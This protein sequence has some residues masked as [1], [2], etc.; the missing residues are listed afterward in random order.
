MQRFKA[1]I[2]YLFAALI[3]F[4]PIILWPYTS[5]VFEFNKIVLV[6]L[7]TTLIVGIWIARSILERKIIFR[8]TILDIPL[9][10][11]I[12]SQF[13]S[14]IIS[15][16]PL[17]SWLGYYSRFNGGL[18][19]VICYSLLYWAFVANFWKEDA[20]K[21]IK[22]LLSSAVLVSLYGILEHF[23]ID[24]DI[25]VQDVQSRVFSTL[26]QPNWLG[27]WITA[28]IPTTWIFVI[29]SKR[30]TL[31]F[32][33]YSTLSILF[34]WVLIFTKS[35]SGILGFVVA[36]AIFWTGYFWLNLKEY[37]KHL[38]PFMA[39]CLSFLAICLISGTQFTPSL[40][41][42]FKNTSHQKEVVAQGPALETGGTESGTIR[43]IVW[44]GAMQVWLHYPV[45]GA[46]V[47]T[48]AFSYY[49][50][51]PQEHNLVSEW[52]FIYN[53]AHNDFLNVAANS[54]TVGLL[55]YL[56]LIG[57]AFYLFAKKFVGYESRVWNL[58]L[59][60]GFVSLSATN[61]FGFS[62]V[63]TQIEFFLF[64]AFAV[65]LAINQPANT[66]N[67]PEKIDPSQKVLL[68]IIAGSVLWILIGT[69][70]YW[71]ADT[72]FANGKAYNS[73]GDSN[74][75]IDYLTKAT[76]LEPNQALYHSELAN[77][78]TN[79][80]LVFYQAKDTENTQKYTDMAVAESERAVSLSPANVNL[81]RARFGVFIMLSTI[82]PNYLIEA[83]NILIEALKE[84]PADAKLYYNLGL[85]YARTGQAEKAI[86][87][88]GKTIE[89][90]SNYKEARLAYAILLI[91]KGDQTGAKAQLEY[92]LAN[93]DSN[94]SL[95]KQTLE[96]VK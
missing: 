41:S 88:L 78:L 72:L 15:I 92:I 9:I 21:L 69:A 40:F 65:I 87:A 81:K 6:Y 29:N 13:I 34:F 44:N 53:K 96:S 84:A 49:K 71:Y 3:F 61:F 93:I 95:T 36:F 74:R 80:A 58:A 77:S 57:A 56:F 28:L 38:N 1:L 20:I 17:T 76:Q 25:W 68:L 39:L 5:E 79:A 52:D 91:N 27:A 62:V 89:L 47:E 30:R 46:G 35:R 75:A 67:Q 66:K 11:F 32:W 94:D 10:I 82:D 64:P 24:K 22:I 63:P 45:F 60:A 18:A 19:S 85:V 31:S 8:R 4:V 70:K 26:G 43:R 90:K 50:Y 59:L 37:K 83:Q 51:R 73:S 2:F 33:V 7:L 54:G 86:E 23:G 48:F 42:L 12:G 16:D 55:S 14:T